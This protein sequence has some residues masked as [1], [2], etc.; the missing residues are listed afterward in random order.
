M[1]LVDRY[2]RRVKLLLKRGRERNTCFPLKHA[3]EEL[4]PSL[5]HLELMRTHNHLHETFN[6][7]DSVGTCC[8]GYGEQ[9]KVQL[10]LMKSLIM[11]CISIRSF[12]IKQQQQFE[13]FLVF[14][15]DHVNFK[16]FILQLQTTQSNIVCSIYFAIKNKPGD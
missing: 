3:V 1:K 10:T 4:F 8:R 15:H 12:Y 6:A 16:I 7:M 13:S 9:R 14:L 5:Y 11:E 2:K